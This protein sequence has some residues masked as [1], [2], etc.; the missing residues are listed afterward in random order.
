[1]MREPDEEYLLD[2]DE[3]AELEAIWDEKELG[4]TYEE[5]LRDLAEEA[6][7]EM[8]RGNTVELD[9]TY[10]EYLRDLAEEE[11]LEAMRDSEYETGYNEEH[12]LEWLPD[13]DFYEPSAMHISDNLS[14]AKELKRRKGHRIIFW[15]DPNDPETPYLTYLEI[16]DGI[17]HI[18]IEEQNR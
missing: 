13:D 3:E 1:M 9:Y 14:K 11:E 8:M 10:E 7:F 4:Y 17:V 6:E 12:P 15:H 5:Y 18:V 2:P 16:M